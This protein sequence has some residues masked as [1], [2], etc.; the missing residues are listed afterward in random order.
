MNS[1]ASLESRAAVHSALGDP[2]RLAIVDELC[3]SDLSP[4]ELRRKFGMESNLLAHHLDVLES[5]GLIERLRSGGDG[6]RRYLRLVGSRL[7]SIIPDS[8]I[9][10]SA[11]LFVCSANSARSQLAAALWTSLTG[12]GSMSAGTRPALEIHPQTFSAATRNG[13]HLR[14]AQPKHLRDI[15]QLP[16]LVITVCDRSHEEIQPGDGWIHWS[17][18]DPVTSGDSE[19][20]DAAVQEL[21]ERISLYIDL[22]QAS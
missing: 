1:P 18:P 19:S 3:R 13:L 11:A 12:L 17:V 5:V 6:R 16:P 14:D 20:F 8:S 7:G 9:K 21:R 10:L 2:I 4:V 22:A 15:H